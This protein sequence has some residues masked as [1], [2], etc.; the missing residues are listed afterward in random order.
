M[1]EYDDFENFIVFDCANLISRNRVHSNIDNFAPQY[2]RDA[3]KGV[4]EMG[5]DSVALLKNSAY[6]WAYKNH[7]GSEEMKILNDL[8]KKEKVIVIDVE[9]DDRMII[10][11]AIA[12]NGLILTKD[13][14]RDHEEKFSPEKWADVKSRMYREFEVIGE[15]FIAPGLPKRELTKDQQMKHKYAEKGMRRPPTVQKKTSNFLRFFRNLR[16][17]KRIEQRDEV[18]VITCL[19]EACKKKV[20]FTNREIEPFTCPH[21]FTRQDPIKGEI[22]PPAEDEVKDP[23]NESKS[24][25][26]KVKEELKNLK[27]KLDVTEKVE[28]I[29][30][31]P[32]QKTKQK[33]KQNNKKKSSKKS[34]PTVSDELIQFIIQN[35]PV[36]P[37]STN[38]KKLS[39]I[40]AEK[41]IPISGDED[42]TISAK[43]RSLNPILFVNKK[44]KTL[45]SRKSLNTIFVKWASNN[46]KENK[47]DSKKLEIQIGSILGQG[48][49]SEE[50]FSSI[51]GMENNIK[52]HQGM[53]ELLQKLGYNITEA[54]DEFIFDLQTEEE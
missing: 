35:V 2:I 21:C 45:I 38:E 36:H 40:L 25:E 29:K 16:Q 50:Q 26:D 1:S 22:L 41:K 31:K 49:V 32:N 7:D 39:K 4:R 20:K 54:G 13:K 23:Q 19:S 53:T 48:T 47:L 11:Y 30:Q 5:Y 6:V 33:P 42:K 18:K 8:I 34:N 51:L 52:S 24:E 46:I 15:K 37:K 9:D 27:I 14:F 3:T 17:P 28:K 10:E 43:I 12:E 44:D